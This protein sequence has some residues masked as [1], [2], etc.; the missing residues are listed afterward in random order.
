MAPDGLLFCTWLDHRNDGT[1]IYGASSTNGG[2]SWHPNRSI[3]ESPSGT[4]CECCHPSVVISNSGS[5]YVMWRNA[6]E[7]NRDMYLA[8]SDDAGQTF[9]FAEKIGVG[10]WKL[11]ACPMDGGDLAV[12]PAGSFSTVWRRNQQI[13]TTDQE[14]PG[15]RLLGK[16]EQPVVAMTARGRYF[17]WLTRRSGDLLLTTPAAT[18][19]EKLAD[20]ASDP[21]IA[22]SR[23]GSGP[24]VA[25]WESGKKPNISIM[26]AIITE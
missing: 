17:V 26:A 9:G 23:S 6:L 24:L 14:K 11:N 5:I 8:R 7:G 2:R 1:Q 25:V 3:Y 15:E 20:D 16:G 13:F 10:T 22:T 21:V 19:P 4:V 12:S 18:T